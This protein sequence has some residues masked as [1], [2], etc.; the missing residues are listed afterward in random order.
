MLKRVGAAMAVAALVCAST[1]ACGPAAAPGSGAS[2]AATAVAA[3]SPRAALFADAE[4]EQAQISPDGKWLSYL[5][6][7]A[8]KR[9]LTAAPLSD[10]VDTRVIAEGAR[11]YF[12][13]ADG[14]FIVYRAQDGGAWHAV[15]LLA[16]GADRVLLAEPDARPFPVSPARAGQVAFAL[17]ADLYEIDIRTGARTNLFRNRAGFSAFLLDAR[18]RPVVGLKRLPAGDVE[19]TALNGA[20]RKLLIVHA[21]DAPDARLIAAAPDGGSF[22]LLSTFGRKH[23]ALMRVDLGSGA[24]ISVAQDEQADVNAVWRTPSTGEVE[25]YAVANFNPRWTPLNQIAAADL[26]LLKQNLQAF[27]I[28]SRSADNTRW[29]VR[30]QTPSLAPRV[31]LYDRAAKKFERL[32]SEHPPLDGSAFATPKRLTIPTRDGGGFDGAL[33]LRDDATDA[34]VVLLR[35]PDAPPFGAFDADA[36]YFTDLGYA[37]LEARAGAGAVAELSRWA[38]GQHLAAAGKNIALIGERAALASLPLKGDFGC[39][40]LVDSPP[41]AANLPD[42]GTEKIL[43]VRRGAA[44]EDEKPSFAAQAYFPDETQSFARAE[45]R[46]A[47]YA[48]AGAFVSGCLGKDVA[49][50]GGD[51][52]NSSLKIVSGQ[53]LIPTLGAAMAPRE[54]EAGAPP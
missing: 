40:V 33:F 43:F 14:A 45:N 35:E 47:F 4:R 5:D 17:G 25:A 49:P 2:S 11:D 42:A 44:I 34:L 12:W 21:A 16:T 51:L 22:L 9:T 23:A 41:Y 8:G 15:D 18:N 13:S 31:W 50:I 30:E 1:A 7:R 10:R 53:V 19:I 38:I 24:M 37:V 36:Q 32:F 26:A 54:T 20:P 27:E 48:L 28:V 52:R 29:I 46:I 39:A 6:R 3:A